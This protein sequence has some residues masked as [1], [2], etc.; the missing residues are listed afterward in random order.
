MSLENVNSGMYLKVALLLGVLTALTYFQH[1]V[2]P[3]STSGTVI[4]QMFIALIKAGLIVSYY[5]HLKYESNVLKILAGISAFILLI[6]FIIVGI[7][8]YFS[9]SGTV[10][11]FG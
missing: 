5:M 2:I 10:D 1:I 4:V 8:A 7:D 9:N 11:F 3:L 6:F